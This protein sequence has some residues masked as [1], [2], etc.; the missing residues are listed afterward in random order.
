RRS[1]LADKP[2]LDHKLKAACVEYNG[3]SYLPLTAPTF[4]KLSPLWQGAKPIANVAIF[5]NLLID[6]EVNATH[7][8]HVVAALER[9][10]GHCQELVI[11]SSIKTSELGD[12]FAREQFNFGSGNDWAKVFR[13]LPY[14]KNVAVV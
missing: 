6:E 3:Q 2:E 9:I 1:T 4:K 13:A 10:G 5:K 8:D 12:V 7:A 11:K 14:L